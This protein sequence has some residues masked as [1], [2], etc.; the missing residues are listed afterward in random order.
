MVYCDFI[1]ATDSTVV[2]RYGGL[3][4]DL[5]GRVSFNR[6]GSGFTIE[7][8]PEETIAFERHLKSIYGA[9]KK[10]FKEGKYKNKLSYEYC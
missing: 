2:Y 10:M 1:R 8:R 5:T 7:K 3:P 9:N 6:D 4:S